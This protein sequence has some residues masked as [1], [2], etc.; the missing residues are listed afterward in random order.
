MT[1]EI[2]AYAKIGVG[3]TTIGSDNFDLTGNADGFNYAAGVNYAFSKHFAASIE[4]NAATGTA[5]EKYSGDNLTLSSA[6][7][8]ATVTYNF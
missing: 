4:Y 5:K 3:T 6:M 8:A 1:K 2:S 7:T